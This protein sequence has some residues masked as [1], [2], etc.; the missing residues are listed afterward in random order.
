MQ[1]RLLALAAMLGTA[2][3]G[4]LEVA[5]SVLRTDRSFADPMSAYA[6]GP[7][8]FVQTVAFVVLALGS[9]AVCAALRSS[10][11][12]PPEWRVARGLIGIWSLGV[13]LAAVFRIDVDGS[14][15]LAGQ[16]HGAVSGLS[17][18]AILAAMFFFTIAAPQVAEWGSFGRPSAAL[19]G[20]AAVGFI[21]A[22]ATQQS[23]TFGVAQ[24]LFLAAVVV[25][26][27]AIGARLYVLVRTGNVVNLRRAL[28]AYDEGD[29]GP[30]ADLLDPAVAW[31][32]VDGMAVRPCRDR[33]AVLANL[34]RH[35]ES[36][37]RLEEL[38][39]AEAG[40]KVV[41]GFRS[42]I[43][44]SRTLEPRSYN[45]FTFD[46]GQVVHIQDARTPS[47]HWAPQA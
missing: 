41:V 36:G 22:G 18:V 17:F 42:P 23:I 26:I 20:T 12:R 47:V 1:D 37:F 32:G 29:L 5:Q 24:R 8:G 3:F 15:S 25:W 21:L 45:V 9:A 7:Y 10:R 33:A 19:A 40:K 30:L 2:T 44:A 31:E 14:T 11:Q 27:V 39:L 13:V 43:A 4:V 38:E 6:V 34:R 16:V 35:L 28:D 46:S